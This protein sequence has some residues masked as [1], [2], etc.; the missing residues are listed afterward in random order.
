MLYWYK[1]A[2]TDR[3]LYQEKQNIKV[4]VYALQKMKKRYEGLEVIP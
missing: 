4:E 2:N 1:S 3:P